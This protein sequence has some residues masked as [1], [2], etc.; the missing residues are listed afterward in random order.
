MQKKLIK[1]NRK[2]SRKLNF[3]GRTVSVYDETF[4][5]PKLLLS[6]PI[7]LP[8]ILLSRLVRRWF[9]LK[10]DRVYALRIG[11]FI[12]ASL[13]AM[14]QY[15]LRPRK[16]LFFRA[17]VYQNPSNSFWNQL[18]K[19]NYLV[20]PYFFRFYSYIDRL[21]PG[22]IVERSDLLEGSN[23]N[24]VD[25][26]FQL[27]NCMP[28][29]SKSELDE[30]KSWLR[31][32]GWNEGEPFVCFHLRDDLYLKNLYHQ[33]GVS[34]EFDNSFRDAHVKNYLKAIEFLNSKGVW[35]IR[36]GKEARKRIGSNNTRLIDYPFLDKK[37]D[38]MDIWLFSNAD[39]V[40]SNSSGPDVLAIVNRIPLLIV[41]GTALNEYHS[42]ADVRW[43]NK[44][45]TW[46]ET[47]DHLEFNE[48]LPL[49]GKDISSFNNLG[50]K[51][52]EANADEVLNVVREFWIEIHLQRRSIS[53]ED[54]RQA[55]FWNRVNSDPKTKSLHGFKHP[56]SRIDERTLD[57]LGI[58]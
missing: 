5:F 1:K 58:K 51:F 10:V 55:A 43:H 18:L 21:V 46:S 26:L 28:R 6:I 14:N 15:V 16:P 47:G 4:F 25:G 2:N 11:N 29:F 36:T 38:L 20:L 17:L 57:R 27:K 19:R 53:L 45:V 41:N 30:A 44:I 13:I 12:P 31:D 37:S 24:D 32:F 23:K 35:V 40:I 50:V 34:S 8:A 54:P 3:L 48:M 42:A 9:V 56:F 52:E 33:Y 39:A 49:F 22:Y 7:F